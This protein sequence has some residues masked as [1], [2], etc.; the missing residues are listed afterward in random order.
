MSTRKPPFRPTGPNP[1]VS[2]SMK[3]RLDRIEATI[4]HI[5]ASTNPTK[6]TPT[7]LATNPSLRLCSH[8]NL[9]ATNCPLLTN[10]TPTNP[11]LPIPLSAALAT[12]RLAQQT[13]TP[14][15][16]AIIVGDTQVDAETAKCVME[17]M[18]CFFPGYG[19]ERRAGH[20]GRAMGMLEGVIR[21]DEEELEEKTFAA[22]WWVG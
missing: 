20:F 14:T 11:I 17:C 16:A 18:V 22:G 2:S 12:Y 1:T 21:G 3:A 8:C 4:D 7:R 15:E 9:P 5:A 13:M 6:R 19:D 10:P